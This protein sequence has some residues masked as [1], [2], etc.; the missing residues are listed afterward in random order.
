MIIN[1]SFIISIVSIVA[2]GLYRFTAFMDYYEMG[3]LVLGGI[4]FIWLGFF[5]YTFKKIFLS[6][7]ALSGLSIFLFENKLINGLPI[8]KTT[9]KEVNKDNPVLNVIY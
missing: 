1:L 9:S 8:N 6:V 4:G 2:L 7:V 5:W 3:I